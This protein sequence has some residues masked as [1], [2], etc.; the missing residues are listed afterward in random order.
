MHRACGNYVRGAE[1]SQKSR[2][3]VKILGARRVTCKKSYTENC[4]KLGATAHSV[5]A[6]ELCT[7]ELAVLCEWKNIVVR[8]LCVWFRASLIYINSCPTRCI[9]KQSVYYFASSLYMIRVSTAP[10]ISSTQ[11]CNY[12]LRYRSYFLCSYLTPTWPSLATLE[13]GSCTVPEAVVT[14]LCSPDDG[15][16]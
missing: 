1:D 4:R 9:T 16:G 12:S 10:I 11:N 14:V 3:Y 5:V 13:G 2:S 6:L 15:C 8:L 7:S